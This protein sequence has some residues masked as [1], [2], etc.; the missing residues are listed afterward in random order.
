M[1]SAFTEPQLFEKVIIASDIESYR[2]YNKEY[3]VNVPLVSNDSLDSI[4][5][6]MKDAIQGS[7]YSKE[8]FEKRKSVIETY[9]NFEQ[10]MPEIL[11]YFRNL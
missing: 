6:M 3:N 2:V 7:L 5:K 9:Y 8:E 4:S 11:E 1:S 10:N